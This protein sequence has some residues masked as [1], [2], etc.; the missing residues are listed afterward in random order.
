MDT[1]AGFRPRFR[2]WTTSRDRGRYVTP[3]GDV[4]PAAVAAFCERALDAVGLDAATPAP[5]ASCLGTWL[6]W[7]MS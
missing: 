7:P 2:V 1:L 6:S 4:D 5:A 3:V